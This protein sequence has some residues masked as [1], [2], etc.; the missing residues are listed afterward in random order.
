M[1]KYISPPRPPGEGLDKLTN[2]TKTSS[3]TFTRKHAIWVVL[4]SGLWLG[5]VVW[6]NAGSLGESVEKPSPTSIAQIKTKPA[7]DEHEVRVAQ[8][9]S[10]KR[11][12]ADPIV[13]RFRQPT[14]PIP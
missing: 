2:A 14:P 3:F 9:E 10:S 6:A 4:S 7:I 11:N 8:K 12:F 13:E 5:L 1:Q